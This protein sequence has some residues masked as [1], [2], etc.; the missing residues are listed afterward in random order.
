M[1]F[2]L[3]AQYGYLLGLASLGA[4]S[5]DGVGDVGELTRLKAQLNADARQPVIVIVATTLAVS[6]TLRSS[7]RITKLW[8]H[9]LGRKNPHSFVEARSKHLCKRNAVDLHDN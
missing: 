9:G 3:S 4:G 1:L 8:H 5:G 2:S 7:W 6:A